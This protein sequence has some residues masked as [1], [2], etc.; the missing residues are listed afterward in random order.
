M[1]GCI[2]NK[3]FNYRIWIE[4]L[5]ETEVI[6]AAVY[7][8]M[9]SYD[10]Q[11][12]EDIAL[13]CFEMNEESLPLI[14][15]FIELRADEYLRWLCAKKGRII[16]VSSSVMPVALRNFYFHTD[17]MKKYVMCIIRLLNR[18]NFFW[19]K[20]RKNEQNRDKQSFLNNRSIHPLI[21]A[22]KYE[23]TVDICMILFYIE[24]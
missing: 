10:N 18:K 16:Y 11:P 5:E 2:G 13:E 21:F 24:T 7:Y 22:E 6:K 20:Q 23:K 19:E 9:A 8:G 14:K 3:I 12:E 17:F 15:A 1:K 4:K